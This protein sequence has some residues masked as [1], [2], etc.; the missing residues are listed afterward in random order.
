MKKHRQNYRKRRKK[1]TNKDQKN[2][3]ASPKGKQKHTQ[4][5]TEDDLR[6]I[7]YVDDEG[8]DIDMTTIDRHKK[9]G[10]VILFGLFLFILLGLVT[11]FGYRVFGQGVE[12]TNGDVTL[13]LTSDTRVASG[14]VVTIEVD[15]VNNKNVNLVSADI[16]LFYPDGFF[17]ENS[18]IPATDANSRVWS[19]E[20]IAPGTGG[21]IRITGQLVG[22]K[23][24]QKKISALLTY[25]PSNFSQDFQ[26]SAEHFVTITSS[27]VD[28]SVD[29]PT[30]VQSGQEFTTTL[31][32][33]NTA[34]LPLNNV[35]VVVDYPTGFTFSESTVDTFIGNNEWRI[36]TLEPNETQTIEITGSLEGNSGE[37]KEMQFRF[38]LIELDNS[39][40]VQIE[41][42]A[43]VL[44]VNPEIELYM[45][46]PDIVEA[47]EAV[48][49]SVT[50][51]N[52]SELTLKKLNVELQLNGKLFAT[53]A[54][55]FEEIDELDSRDEITLDHEFILENKGN[56][57]EEMSIVATIASAKA[58]GND[59]SFSNEATVN[60]KTASAAVL[61]AIGQYFDS[62]LKK[63]GDG[64]IPP[65]VGE[66]TTYV[67][68][69]VVDNGA[70]D[71]QN[72]NFVTTLPENVL[73]E[74]EASAAIEYDAQKRTVTYAAPVIEAQDTKTLTFS[75]S[76]IPE[77]QDVNSLMVLTKETI[78]S[79]VDAFTG[80]KI[81]E[82][83]PR[84][85]TDLPNDEGASG[86]GIVE[87]E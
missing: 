43:I 67:I 28:F 82:E 76:I 21:K 26:V 77:K 2:H 46:A 5:Q 62:N 34:T 44:V 15:Y 64:P 52:T 78:I 18:N 41:K 22:E 35:K 39:F 66:K 38:G 51:K 4:K 61:S 3:T 60:M 9:R 45:S 80:E 11:Y 71:L 36:E 55:A 47:G 73:W 70:N 14:D 57:S 65:V 7:Y 19:L 68:Q 48:P 8:K 49:V 69:W 42:T 13:E 79:G 40:N 32:Y 17:V 56:V 29:T 58:E 63:I 75:V 83:I 59:I 37:S 20:D 33:T 23:D 74:D 31:E 81:S 87:A 72:V 10:R 30:Q 25:Q 16:E 12:N 1:Q 85:T 53:D 86:K 54:Y 24:E 50:V 27:I 84:I 6:S